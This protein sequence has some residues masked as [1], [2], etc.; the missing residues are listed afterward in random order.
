MILYSAEK[1]G[2]FDKQIHG[3]NVPEDTVEITKNEYQKM[4]RGQA[5]G[6]SI[7]PDQDG[8]PQLFKKEK[9][10]EQRIRQIKNEIGYF[11]D[12]QAQ[13]TGPFGFDNI[14]SAVSYADDTEDTVNQPYGA[15]L[16]A[17]RRE[18]W[19]KARE[20]FVTWQDGGPEPTLQEVIDQMPPFINPV[21]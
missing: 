14:I 4:L 11:I 15:A 1:N 9:T 19:N 10:D 5:D 21:V 18:C 13:Q 12:R 3:E 8:K 7:K 20:I 16:K 2:F 6:F 17:W